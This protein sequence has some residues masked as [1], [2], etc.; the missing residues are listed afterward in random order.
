MGVAARGP[1]YNNHYIAQLY[2]INIDSGVATSILKPGMQIAT[3]RWSPDGKQIAFIGG[4]MAG[5]G[6]GRSGGGDVYVMPAD[7]GRARDITPQMKATAWHL[8][9]LSPHQIL[10]WETV[11]GDTGLAEVDLEGGRIEQLWRS[12]AAGGSL[13]SFSVARDGKTTAESLSSFD[14]PPEVW[15]GPIGAWK[16]ITN[17]NEGIRPNWGKVESLEWPS[18]G[19]QVQGWLYYPAN[20]DPHRRYPMIVDIHGGPTGTVVPVWGGGDPPMADAAY[21]VA[22]YFVLVPN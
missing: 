17:L 8:I 22:G 9:W 15:A 5:F 6:P 4:L 13:G 21:S 16:Q 20:Y 18:D 11:F 19:W 3:P 2:R 1:A 10:F 7:G 12:S 14:R